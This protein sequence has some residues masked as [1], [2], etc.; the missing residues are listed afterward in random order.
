MPTDESLQLYGHSG[1]WNAYVKTENRVAVGEQHEGNDTFLHQRETE[2]RRD[3]DICWLSEASGRLMGL[4]K[5]NLIQS[6]HL[7]Y[8]KA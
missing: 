6:G 4:G 1:C 5:V 8:R 2:S 3:V 7:R